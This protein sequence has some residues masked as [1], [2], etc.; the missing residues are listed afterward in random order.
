MCED[1]KKRK[2]I[3]RHVRKWKGLTLEELEEIDKVFHLFDKDGS[4]NID[5]NELKDAMT[6]LG[7]YCNKEQLR[8]FMDKA[9]KDGSG[10]I[11]DKEFQSLMAELINRRDP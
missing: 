9:D 5:S 1:G 4:G 10:T 11:E 3:L 2:K 8:K 7:I 6:A